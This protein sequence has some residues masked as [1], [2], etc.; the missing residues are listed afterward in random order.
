[1]IIPLRIMSELKIDETHKAIEVRFKF[2]EFEYA[3]VWNCLQQAGW[4]YRT[5]T[6]SVTGYQYQAPA[7]NGP[8]F[9]RWEEVM[10]YLDQYALPD[11]YS[12]LELVTSNEDF[13]TK[14]EVEQGMEIRR[15]ALRMM[16][17]NTK[18]ELN[19]RLR[20][21]SK[22]NK[23]EPEHVMEEGATS[24]TRRNTLPSSKQ[25]STTQTDVGTDLY[26][27]GKRALNLKRKRAPVTTNSARLDEQ[28]QLPS[29]SQ[30]ARH[31]QENNHLHKDAAEYE[32]S[33]KPAFP[34]WRFLLS[35]NHS[36]LF[37]GAGSKYDLLTKFCDQEL[38]KEGYVLQIDGFD[39]DISMTKVLDLLVNQFLGGNEPVSKGRIESHDGTHKVLG[40]SIPWRAHALVER[41]ILVGRACAY[42]ASESLLPIFLVIHSL[43]GDSLRSKLA[44]DALAALVV[45]SNVEVNAHAIRLVAS[46]DHIS[47]SE[48]MFTSHVAANLAWIYLPLH[49]YRP[50]VKELVMLSESKKK[51]AIH[52][53]ELSQLERIERV[54]GVL[55][56]LAPRHTEVMQVLAK[57]Q[58]EQTLEESW[59][60]MPVFRK[61]CKNSHIIAKDSG[62]DSFLNEL[63]DHGLVQIDRRS[64]SGDFIRAP[65]NRAKLQQILKFQPG[66]VA[67]A[68]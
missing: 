25:G 23:F 45:N 18:D 6:L 54:E 61:Q 17:E 53:A 3:F 12:T 4:S 39:K 50:Y 19:K 21:E 33:Y 60:K 67:L 34:H 43:D 41:A 68:K 9:D 24:N 1:M 11:V 46:V 15:Q 62:L 48:L 2:Q 37:L 30:V 35:T 55:E 40:E 65:F 52:K 20:H 10:A 8:R 66:R 57:L 63:T 26:L 51:S 38:R 56:L 59:V 49:T 36:L 13:Q 32:E 28:L 64:E 42:E 16:F 44:T 58:L 22:P 14:E 31:L 47:A 7:E 27:H 5:T 29:I